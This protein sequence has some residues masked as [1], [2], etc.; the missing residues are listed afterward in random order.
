[1]TNNTQIFCD[2]DGVLVDFESTA[3]SLTNN[4]LSGGKLPGVSRSKSHFYR[5]QQVHDEMGN[6]WRLTSGNDL[7]IPVVRK[8]MLTSIAANPGLIFLSM[9]P[10][11]DGVTQLWPFINRV[12]LT[13]N[14]LSA[15]ING[16]KSSPMTAAD[17]K[18]SW[19]ENWLTPQPK[20]IIITPSARK[21]EHA[22]TGGVKN[23]LIDDK[24]STIDA[25]NAAGGIGILH[26]PK[27]SAKTIQQLTDILN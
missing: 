10:H 24:A 25:W 12:G 17:G 8:L 14:I 9:Q 5:V 13:V 27:N 6:D 4:I 21:Y 1:M 15:P 22:T 18:T 11:Q 23:I 19:V 3:I 16:N 20:N 7:Q 26:T 2:M